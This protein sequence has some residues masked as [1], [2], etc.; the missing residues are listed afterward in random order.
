MWKFARISYGLMV[1]NEEVEWVG[2][3]K[4]HIIAVILIKFS[5]FIFYMNIIHTISTA[6]NRFR[7][8]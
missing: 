2:Q 5:I 4:L 8:P 3:I 7:F 6:I 1:A